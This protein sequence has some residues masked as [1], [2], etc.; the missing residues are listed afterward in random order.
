MDVTSSSE[1]GIMM[2]LGLL[3]FG[4]DR[5]I[6]FGAS[7][8]R[9]GRGKIGNRQPARNNLKLDKLGKPFQIKY[10]NRGSGCTVQKRSLGMSLRGGDTSI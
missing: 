10:R 1:V 2:V 6:V 4:T 8:E 9:R 3:M 7:Q 5:R